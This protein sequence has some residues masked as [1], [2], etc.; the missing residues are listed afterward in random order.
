MLKSDNT[1]VEARGLIR[2]KEVNFLKKRW[3]VHQKDKKN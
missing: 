2:D 1:D 3:S